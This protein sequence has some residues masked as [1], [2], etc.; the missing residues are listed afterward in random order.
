VAPNV[1]CGKQLTRRPKIVGGED[2][3]QGE[4]PWLVSVKEKVGGSFQH[5][6]GGFIV[7]DQYILSAA[8][9]FERYV[10]AGLVQVVS[11]KRRELSFCG[12]DFIF[13]AAHK[14][15]PGLALKFWPELAFYLFFRF[16]FL[17]F[18][19][20]FIS[21]QFTK[22]ET[23]VFLTRVSFSPLPFPKQALSPYSQTSLAEKV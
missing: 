3:Y 8:H 1:V 4:F 18:F 21:T 19:F 2:A 9:C 14:S 22:V 13:R 23:Q 16:F 10:N 5:V 11:F 12:N 17:L 20:P 15:L 6:C 7:G